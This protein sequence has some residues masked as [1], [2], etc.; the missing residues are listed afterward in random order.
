MTK[1]LCI[2]ILGVIFSSS[3]IFAQNPSE[4]FIQLANVEHNEA[5]I[6]FTGDFTRAFDGEM[7]LVSFDELDTESNV[8]IVNQFGEN[9][10]STLIQNGFEKL[11]WVTLSQLFKPGFQMESVV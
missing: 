3:M 4:V 6:Q 5:V 11:V 8:A 2:I 10:I 1:T 7:G 9:Y